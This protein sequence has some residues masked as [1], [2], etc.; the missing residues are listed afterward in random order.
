VPRQKACKQS[1]LINVEVCSGTD[2]CS[3]ST[4]GYN[5]KDLRCGGE[6]SCDEAVIAHVDGAV[7][8]AGR[9]SCTEMEV[10][11][12]DALYCDGYL[13]CSH[14]TGVHGVP[15]QIYA[16][17]RKALSESDIQSLDANGDAL[18]LFEVF[19]SS[20]KALHK[21]TIKC[22]EGS[23]CK[24]YCAGSSCATMERFEC[25]SAESCSCEGESCPEIVVVIPET[26]DGVG[27]LSLSERAQLKQQRMEA[28]MLHAEFGATQRAVMNEPLVM[29]IGAGVVLMVL[30]AVFYLYGREDKNVYQEL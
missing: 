7:F 9:N 28:V 1:Q 27:R 30:A 22:V 10:R 29:L 21:T 14:M 4:V 23:E 26:I 17:G 8:C 16:R 6:E 5:G 2:A 20:G 19:A 24:L 12:A 11:A 18:E 3:S 25:S 13:T 15:S